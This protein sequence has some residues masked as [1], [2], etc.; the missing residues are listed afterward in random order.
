MFFEHMII[1]PV[2]KFELGN[3]RMYCFQLKYTRF[4]GFMINFKLFKVEKVV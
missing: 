2:K 1:T 4:D 3:I